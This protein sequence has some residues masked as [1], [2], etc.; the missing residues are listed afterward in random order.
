MSVWF[1]IGF[2][3]IA[4]GMIQAATLVGSNVSDFM[5]LED[6]GLEY[7][8]AGEAIGRYSPGER[9]QFLGAGALAIL[10]LLSLSAGAISQLKR[11]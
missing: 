9:L 3:L 2:S 11:R 7:T 10:G 8:E 4:F 1:K 5:Y 6:L